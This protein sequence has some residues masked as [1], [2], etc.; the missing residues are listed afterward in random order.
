MQYISR[1]TKC[2]SNTKLLQLNNCKWT[3][4]TIT[5]SSNTKQKTKNILPWRT[6]ASGDTTQKGTTSA[7]WRRWDQHDV[8]RSTNA[9]MLGKGHNVRVV[10]RDIVD[11]SFW[12]RQ[13][14]PLWRYTQVYKSQPLRRC[15]SNTVFVGY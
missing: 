5:S 9:T 8:R 1:Y 10:K 6:V 3:L 12:F 15:I 4:N 11:W 2:E 14:I 13:T 7:T